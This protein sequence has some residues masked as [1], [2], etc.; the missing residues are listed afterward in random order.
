MRYIDTGSRDPRHAL[1]SW[2][3]DTLLGRAPAVALRIQTG[4]FGSDTLGYFESTFQDLSKNDGH[5]VVLVGSNEGL[6]PRAAV[7]DLLEIAG[8][9][10][11]GLRVG[12][13]SFRSG[14]FHPK[15]YH[16]ERAD[17]SVTAYVGSANLTSSGATSLHVEAGI[18]LDT[19]QGDAPAVLDSIADAI[20]GWFS[21][22]RPG[23][24]PITTDADL[25][26]LV[27]A[28]I[29]GVPAPPRPPRMSQAAKAGMQQGSA[30]HSLKPLVAIP[31]T[32]A[33][34][35]PMPQGPPDPG[36]TGQPS[37]RTT[38][39]T[40]PTATPGS[41]PVT[42]TPPTPTGAVKHWGKTL[43]VSDAQRKKQGNQRGAITLVQGDYRGQIDQTVYFRYDLFS[44]AHWTPG[45]A[46]TGQPI[47][48]AMVPMHVTINGTYHGVM[49]FK[50][51]N[52]SNRE[53]AQNNYTA[54]L[55]VEPVTPLFRQT[56]MSGRHLDIALDKNGEFWLTIA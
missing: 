12:V 42:P 51:T 19:A 13:V 16:F 8:T 1:G 40:G 10:R 38:T 30:D 23:L 35:T 53:A 20:D 11:A 50:V 4:F 37:T 7:S 6:T 45:M 25:D 32:Q 48:T 9:P 44:Q 55:H 39:T 5:T 28:D 49:D 41:S 26:A 27:A 3:G 31:A 36:P 43:S 22:A 34:L 21:P 33:T 54:E 56:N 46:N 24:Y 18:I 14:F 29:L 15:V 17:G 52:G 47:E 2:L